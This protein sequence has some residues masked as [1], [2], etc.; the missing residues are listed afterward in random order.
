MKIKIKRNILQVKKSA[1]S[2]TRKTRTRAYFMVHMNLLVGVILVKSG[3][4]QIY[5]WAWMVCE[6]DVH[7]FNIIRPKCCGASRAFPVTTFDNMLNT[8]MT[9]QVVAFRNYDL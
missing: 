9:K 4:D 8:L 1:K 2:A 7:R 6:S 3:K 5:C